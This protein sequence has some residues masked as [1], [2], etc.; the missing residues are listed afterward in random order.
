MQRLYK[1]TIMKK[2]MLS[3]VAM[4]A[5][6]AAIAQNDLTKTP[7]F[8]VQFTLNDFK[9]PASLRSGGIAAAVKAEDWSKIKEMSPGI[10]LSYL[11]GLSENID[12][13]G[14]LSASFS[15]VPVAGK[16]VNSNRYLLLDLAAT[17]N[18]KLLND[19][20]FVTPFL[21]LGAGVSK[22][23]GYFSAFVPAGVGLQFKLGPESLLLVN[24]Q[25]RIPVTDNGAYNLFHAIGFAQT[26]ERKET[27]V[28][29]SPGL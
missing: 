20:Y 17:A 19:D 6:T 26:M 8:A 14:T 24:S 29:A 15:S 18:L 1:T 9:T 23:K 22:Y 11:Q 28:A 27:A 7:G 5:F 16:P 10:A 4:A 3:L 13:Q 2:I 12:F 21:T 25:Y